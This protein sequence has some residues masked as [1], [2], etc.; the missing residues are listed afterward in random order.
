MPA[1][2]GTLKSGD[3]RLVS[4]F[5]IQKV[6][7]GRSLSELLPQ[8]LD[9]LEDSRDRGLVQAICF[10]VMRSYLKLHF[11]QRQLMAKPL[12]SKDRDIEALILIGLYQLLYL[13]VGDH[14]AVHETAGAANKLRKRWAVGLINGVLRNF[15]RQREGLIEAL[16]V[17]PEA[18]YA[19]PGWLL[20]ALQT[21]WPESWRQRVEAL[22]SHPPMSLR[23]NRQDSSRDDYLD[24]LR[25][26][27]IGAEPI[28]LVESGI[29]LTKAMDVESLPGFAR[30]RVSVQDGA[31]QLAAGLLGLQPGQQVL[32]ACAAP[33]GKS[34]HMLEMEPE[35]ELTAL[36][37]DSERL[38]RVSD[39]LSRIGLQASLQLGD[40]ANPSGSWA[41]QCYDRILLD[42]PCSATGV[43]RRHPDIKYLRRETDIFNLVKLQNKI[44]NA[45]WQLLKP[46]GVMLYA[47]CS[48]LPQENEMQL[49]QFLARQA[50]AMEDVMDVT[51]GEARCVGRQIAP[52][53]DGLDGFYYAR[54]IKRA[55]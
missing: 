41:R 31:A 46:G 11:I 37:S 21:Q 44:L 39:N 5:V 10:G 4:A 7:A 30:G 45:V 47:T 24:L 25:K 38:R 51:W 12:K 13:R 28:P 54:L 33:G 6:L 16:E 27:G 29:N 3:P 34:C 17:E 49:Q 52:G 9:Q 2:T 23:V 26:N 42:L 8:Y 43:I 40:A 14:A 35:I 48:I 18:R 15:Q 36:D 53:L 20:H 55:T 19:M 32:D 50:D 22:N 1:G